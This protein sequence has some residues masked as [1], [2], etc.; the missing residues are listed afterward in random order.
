MDDILN[1]NEK[2]LVTVIIPIYNVEA[3]LPRCLNSVIN[4]SYK[5][6]EIILVDDGSKD[7]SSK[8][9]D[10]YAKM[11]SRITVYH[12]E[13]GGLSSARNKGLDVAK[14]KYITLVDSDDWIELDTIEYSV[15]LLNKVNA[16]IVQ[17]D[18]YK[19][20]DCK[21][22]QKRKERL[23]L[24]KEK[25]IL[26]FLM[27]NSTKSDTYYASVRCVYKK[28]TIG[29]L[30]FPE[31][32]VNEDIIWKYKVLQ[33]AKMLVNSNLGK[34]YY[35]QNTG[36]ITRGGL[37]EKDFDLYI[38][39]QGIKDLTSLEEYGKI[40]K[41]GE[42][43]YARTSLSLLCKIAYYGISDEKINKKEIVKKL[44]GELRRNAG[45]LLSSPM[46]ISRKIL[47]LMFYIN[48]KMTE[49]SIKLIKKFN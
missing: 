18:M 27:V 2:D 17:Y 30:R 12:K 33:R 7:S 3:Y 45:I 6:L 23:L 46:P 42:V 37:K 47:V 11:D 5:N 36:S 14:G 21:P 34:Y 9:C 19:V 41:M 32:L 20:K 40:R 49:A 35:F 38:A 43:K 24:L 1:I 48:Y 29:D 8:I 15:Q 39:A 25:E 4:Q 22:P 26:D 10:E 16:D 13:N 44:Q 28:E 31:G